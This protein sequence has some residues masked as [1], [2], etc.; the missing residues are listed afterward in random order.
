VFEARP[1]WLAW[2]QYPQDP[3]G[4]SRLTLA[5]PTIR[6]RVTGALKRMHRHRSSGSPIR[7]ELAMH[8][9][10]EALLWC[11]LDRA[12]QVR[13]LDPRVEAAVQ[14]LRGN[15]RQSITLEELARASHASRARLAA[16]FRRQVGVPPM[17]YLERERINLATQMLDMTALSVKEIAADVGFEDARYFAKRFRRITGLTPRGFREQRAQAQG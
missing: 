16:L 9:L 13:R 10:E 7:V 4:Y 12:R 8:A 1:H 6:R 14:H 15:L 3:E 2:L 17:R 11:W 5:D